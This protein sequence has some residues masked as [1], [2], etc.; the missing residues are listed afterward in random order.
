MTTESSSSAVVRSAYVQD[1][2]KR[3]QRAFGMIALPKSLGDVA[4]EACESS[5]MNPA[6]F[7]RYAIAIAVN[8][9]VGWDLRTVVDPNQFIPTPKVE[10]AKTLKI[11][12]ETVNA[13]AARIAQLEAMLAAQTKTANV[14]TANAMGCG[15]CGWTSSSDNAHRDDCKGDVHELAVT[16]R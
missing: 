6:E 13:Q 14:P 1:L 3:N 7:T 4:W 8:R 5:G 11:T 2:E 15:T 16:I 12:R 9:V 10:A